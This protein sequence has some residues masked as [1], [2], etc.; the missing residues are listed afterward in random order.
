M[1]ALSFGILLLSAAL[2]ISSCQKEIDPGPDNRLNSDSTYLSKFFY[3]D[4][5]LP[6]GNDTTWAISY[7]YDAQKRPS[8]MIEWDYSSGIAEEAYTT[9]Y[10]YYGNDT[11][12]VN[13]KSY[14]IWYDST[15]NYFRYSNGFIVYDSLVNYD[16]ANNAVFNESVITCLPAGNGRYLYKERFNPDPVTGYP[17]AETVDS[18]IFART[19]VNGN[20]VAG[21]DSIWSAGVFNDKRVFQCSFDQHNNPFRRLASWY[22]GYF[23]R[24][25]GIDGAHVNNPVMFKESFD[26][27]G[28]WIYNTSYDYNT[29]RY[30]VIARVSWTGNWVQLDYNKI[31]MKYVKL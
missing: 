11:L 15:I 21:V 9:V 3:L 16:G 10:R 26:V 8:K 14:S 20:V 27:L 23:S 18:V 24:R 19:L 5:T 22:N 31:V 12:P 29:D 4:T 30:P 13:L 7:E 17:P 1:R 25:F 6:A 28:T 2:G